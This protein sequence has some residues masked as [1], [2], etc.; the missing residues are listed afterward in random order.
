MTSGRVADPVERQLVQAAVV[1]MRARI[2][3][4]VFGMVGGTGLFAATLWLVIQGGPNVGMHLGLLRNYFPGY[5]VTWWGSLLGF[6]YGALAG[7]IVGYSV[8][9]IYN[10]ISERRQDA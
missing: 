9:W 6:V 7:G 1:R 5:A 10:R 3:A 4:L 2:M 8:A